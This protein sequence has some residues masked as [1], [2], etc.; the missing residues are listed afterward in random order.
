MKENFYILGNGVLQAEESVLRFNSRDGFRRIPVENIRSLNIYG[1]CSV[2]S[3]ALNTSAKH[4]IVL[5]FFGYYGNYVGSFWPK[6]QYFSGDLTIEQVKLYLN[7]ERRLDLCNRLVEGIR[8]NMKSFLSQYGINFDVSEIKGNSV[9]ELMLIEARMRKNYYEKL[10]SL[11]PDTFK[12]NKRVKHPPDNFGNTLISFGNSRLYSELV[13]QSRYVSL[14]PTISFYHSPETSRYSLVLD[15]SEVF[16]PF[17]VDKFILKV[18]KKNIITKNSFHK[19]G[20]GILL[21]DNGRKDF[22]KEWERWLNES[23]FYGKLNR[24]ISNRELLKIELFKLIKNYMNIAQ[25]VPFNME[26]KY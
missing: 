21:N 2:T 17:L 4:N 9:E 1:G 23:Y 5:N 7:K 16:K 13:T 18:I 22:L 8:V 26:V 15:I 20:N 11:L 10:D 24:N 14:N 6:E 25:Y 19:E 3:G 12:I